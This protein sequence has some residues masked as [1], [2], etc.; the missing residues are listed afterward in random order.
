[1]YPGPDLLQEVGRVTIAG[2]RLDL[3]MGFLWHHLDLTVDEAHS[4]KAPG[5]EQCRRIRR[6]AD[7]RLTG[8]LR[9]LVLAAVL[10]AETA[11]QHR[12]EIVHQDWILRG[13]EAMRPV[14]EFL[15]LSEAD[16]D[17]Y[18]EEWSREARDSANWQRVPARS[19]DVVPAQTLDELRQIERE[20]AA[21]TD[22]VEQLVYAVASSRDTGHPAGYVHPQT[23]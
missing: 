11:R 20:L 6:L 3:Q 4:R 1:M 21:A 17:A 18:V 5:A 23:P 2:S 22:Q 14:G 15:T 8:N 10:A 12:N 16:R 13:R 7:E 19:T 9:D